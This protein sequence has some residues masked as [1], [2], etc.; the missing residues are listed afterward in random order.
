[1][2]LAQMA[3]A[4]CPRDFAK[5]SKGTYFEALARAL[6]NLTELEKV[7]RLA[8]RTTMPFFL[9]FEVGLAA[10]LRTQKLAFLGATSSTPFPFPRLSR[11][12]SALLLLCPTPCKPNQMHCCSFDIRS[13]MPRS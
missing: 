8:C 12:R 2:D 6:N 7:E 3:Q 9:A 4:G 11:L 5:T 13:P 1:M 10:A